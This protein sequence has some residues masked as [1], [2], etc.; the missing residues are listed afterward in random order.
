MQL[1]GMLAKGPSW[2]NYEFTSWEANYRIE[3]LFWEQK[4]G[5]EFSFRFGNQ[6]PHAIL[7][8]FR[9]KDAPT[10]FT[11]SPV[12]FSESIPYPASAQAFP[13]DGA[14]RPCPASSRTRP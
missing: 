10:S 11:A 4:I 14:P 1:W 5:P 12:A 13:F 9:F 2:S 6:A 7:N 3:E 8:T